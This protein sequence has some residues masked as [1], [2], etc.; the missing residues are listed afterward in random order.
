[1]RWAQVKVTCPTASL[2]DVCAV[3]SMVDSGLMIEDYRDIGDG[4][5]AMYGE[6]IDEE[7]LKCDKNTAGVISVP[8]NGAGASPTCRRASIKEL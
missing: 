8:L 6:L 1:M 4:M 5:N 7:L 3:M 2:D